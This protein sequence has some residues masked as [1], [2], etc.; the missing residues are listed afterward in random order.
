VTQEVAKS[1]DNSLIE[2][3]TV[4][5]L[6]QFSEEINEIVKKYLKTYYEGIRQGQ[7]DNEKKEMV[8]DTRSGR[9]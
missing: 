1:E 7:K 3:S 5:F 2:R 6:G 8:N 4:R 9:Y